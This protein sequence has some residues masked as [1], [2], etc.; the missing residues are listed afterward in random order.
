MGDVVQLKAAEL[1]SRILQTQDIKREPVEVP[2]WGVTLYVRGMTGRERDAY[3]ESLVEGRGRKA[4][5]RLIG[6]RAR[7]VVMCTEDADGNRVFTD[8][9]AKILEQK[10]AAAL[11]RL[12]TRIRDLSGMTP[13]DEAELEGEENPTSDDSESDLNDGSI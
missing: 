9:D 1:R 12:W 4:R 13:E 7:M 10:S 2:E 3:E 8:A 6:A 11:E 5:L